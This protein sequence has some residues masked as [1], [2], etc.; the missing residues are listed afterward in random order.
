MRSVH[1]IAYDIADPKR[2]RKV[3]KAMCGAGDALQFS[4]FRCELSAMELQKLKDEVWPLLNLAED[5]VMI[6]D[7]GPIEGRGDECIEFW[8]NPRTIPPDRSAVVV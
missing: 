1:V 4:V 3:Y 7:L 6:V 2:Y 8:G 5:R